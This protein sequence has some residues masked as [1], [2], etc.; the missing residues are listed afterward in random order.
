MDM[1]ST[2]CGWARRIESPSSSDEDI[3]DELPEV[4]SELL[5]SSRSVESWSE[6]ANEDGIGPC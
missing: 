2:V 1:V 5:T 6:L 4:M 3:V